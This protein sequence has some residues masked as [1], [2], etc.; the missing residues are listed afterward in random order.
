MM[1]GLIISIDQLSQVHWWLVCSLAGLLCLIISIDQFVETIS[2]GG[3]STINLWLAGHQEATTIFFCLI[4][5]GTNKWH[6]YWNFYVN[7]PSLGIQMHRPVNLMFN[8]LLKLTGNMK[9]WHC[10]NIVLNDGNPYAMTVLPGLVTFLMCLF[11]NN[12]FTFM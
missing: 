9:F 3:E 4:L 8:I 11:F 12:L 2:N 5:I 1:Q 10:G 7:R 6:H